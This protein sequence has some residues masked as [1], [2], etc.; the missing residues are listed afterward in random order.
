MPVSARARSLRS[1]VGSAFAALE[2]LPLDL[3][4]DRRAARPRRA[5]RH[6]HRHLRARRRSARWR[7]RVP[8]KLPSRALSRL[9]FPP[10]WRVLLIFDAGARRLAG[11]NETAAFATLPD[12]PESETADLTRRILHGALPAL[13]A[14]RLHGFLRAGRLPAGRDGHLFRTDA[15]RPLCQRRRQPPCSSGSR[16]MA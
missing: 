2:G 9:P 13:A 1:P 16:Q 7:P 11:A 12:F 5:L 4:R 10:A 15:G 14:G 8:D 3:Q 6:R